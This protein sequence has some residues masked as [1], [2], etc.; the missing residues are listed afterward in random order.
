MRIP[1]VSWTQ[2]ENN[3]LDGFGLHPMHDVARR[4]GMRK[5]TM[6]LASWTSPG[7][8]SVATMWQNV[9][10]PRRRW[11]ARFPKVQGPGV[12][13]QGEAT[14]WLD[15]A[16]WPVDLSQASAHLGRAGSAPDV[17]QNR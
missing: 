14:G 8:G 6:R 9:R 7:I 2:L 12:S 4:F 3:F 16:H 17:R 11:S 13:G 5:H 15:M 1:L 10:P